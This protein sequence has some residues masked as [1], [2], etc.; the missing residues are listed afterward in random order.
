MIKTATIAG[1]GAMQKS[2][3]PSVK[4]GQGSRVVRNLQVTVNLVTV[5]AWPSI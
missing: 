3:W 4:T 5:T 2:C 1:A